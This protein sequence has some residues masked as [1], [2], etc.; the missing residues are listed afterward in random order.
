M[1]RDVRIGTC[2]FNG[3]KSRY[4]ALFSSVEVQQT[5]YQPPRVPTLERW[6][7]EVPLD[8]EFTLKAW[9]LI[10]HEAKSPTYK[11]LKRNLSDQERTGTGFF[12]PTPIVEE[13]WQTTRACADAL[14][15]NVI[16]FQCPASFDQTREHI[17][18]MVRFF[19]GIERNGLT[20]CW[21]PR[22]PWD[23][24][25]VKALCEDLNLWHVVDP[26]VSTTM[27]PEQCYFRLH[28]RNGWRYKYEPQELSDLAELLPPDRR[29]YVF[30]NNSYMT[31]DAQVFKRIVETDRDY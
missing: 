29:A 1:Q 19:S 16:L 22:G 23:R 10:T 24:Q 25:V 11:R 9:Q 20:L 27:T 26:F 30:F 17:S 12:K 14:R 3:T 5:F 28:G 21:E 13:A 2:G 8:F 6:R 15:A 7:T 31:E 18:N 4:A